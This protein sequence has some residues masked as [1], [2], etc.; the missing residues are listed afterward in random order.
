MDGSGTSTR[1]AGA[2]ASVVLLTAQSSDELWREFENASRRHAAA[3]ERVAELEV[4]RSRLTADRDAAVAA[5]AALRIEA[6]D[7][8]VM[9]YV[10]AAGALASI[11]PVGSTRDQAV[12]TALS[13]AASGTRV[14]ALD[15]YR[16]LLDDLAIADTAL[17]DAIEREA[18]AASAAAAEAE[19]L[20]TAAERTAAIEEDARRAAAA[21]AIRRAAEEQAAADAARAAAAATT[22]TTTTTAAPSATTAGARPTSSTPAPAPSSTTS[23]T[24]AT[25]T[26]VTRPPNLPPP[27]TIPDSGDPAALDPN[28][29]TAEQLRRL[30]VCESGDNYANTSNPRYRGAYQFLRTT[31]DAVALRAGRADLVGVDPAAALPEDQDEMAQTLYREQ[32]LRPWPVCGR[33]VTA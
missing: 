28:G 27:T 33:R 22:T 20:R 25:T 8:V 18:D 32:G 19:S 15:D 5:A 14:D 9:Q 16:S 17:S 1:R 11:A 6:R 2:L 30:R 4:E 21:E 29:L 31:W 23:T 10:D 12:R 7:A 26:T 3:A 13:E 24:R